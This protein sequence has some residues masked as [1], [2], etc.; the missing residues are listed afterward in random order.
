MKKLVLFTVITLFTTISYC[1]SNKETYQTIKIENVGELKISTVVDIL[2]NPTTPLS[3]DNEFFK[4]VIPFYNK[5]GYIT[6]K[7]YERLEDYIA[8]SDLFNRIERKDPNKL[9]VNELMDYNNSYQQQMSKSLKHISICTSI[10][11]TTVIL[12]II[13]GI[14]FAIS[15]NK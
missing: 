4:E 2:T 8:S 15:Q 7:Q 12:G 5:N 6:A 9:T 10:T 3:K 11:T 13:G 1:Q 14:I